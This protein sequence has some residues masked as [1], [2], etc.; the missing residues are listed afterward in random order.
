MDFLVTVILVTTIVIIIFLV[1]TLKKVQIRIGALESKVSWFWFFRIVT[2]MGGISLLFYFLIPYLLNNDFLY[3]TII[4]IGIFTSVNIFAWALSWRYFD[5]T[6]CYGNEGNVYMQKF[7]NYLGE[8][9]THIIMFFFRIGINLALIF[10]FLNNKPLF[11]LPTYVGELKIYIGYLVIC[12]N[13]AVFTVEMIEN[14]ISNYY[15]ELEICSKTP[16]KLCKKYGGIWCKNID[17]FGK[18]K[19]KINKK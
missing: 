8:D 4:I 18:E 19:K 5:K 12:F 14:I 17:F 7:M 1:S 9:W 13:T 3:S 15:G 11:L 2:E 16:T 6:N 10:L